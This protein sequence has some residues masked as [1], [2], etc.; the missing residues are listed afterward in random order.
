MGTTEATRLGIWYGA[1]GVSLAMDVSWV[2][3]LDHKADD[4]VILPGTTYSSLACSQ[5][6]CF[7]G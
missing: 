7:M 5:G 2:F 6:W 3:L 1:T 4:R